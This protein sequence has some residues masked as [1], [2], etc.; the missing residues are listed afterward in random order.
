[1]KLDE[2]AKAKVANSGGFRSL[3]IRLCKD[4]R[5]VARWLDVLFK[6]EYRY[7]EVSGY[8][9]LVCNVERMIANCVWRS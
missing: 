7:Y 5:Q 8:N 9:T 1:M 4:R 6:S 3:E 2:Q